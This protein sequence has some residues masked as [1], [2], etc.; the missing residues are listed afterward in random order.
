[1]NQSVSKTVHRVF[2]DELSDLLDT[3]LAGEVVADRAIA[4]RLVRA[5]G[6]IVHLHERHP[7]DARCRCQVCW[8]IPRRW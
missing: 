6:T 1:M 7:I 8:A 5:L 4:E 3:V 2:H